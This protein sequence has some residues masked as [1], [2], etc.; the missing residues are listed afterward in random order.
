MWL[1]SLWTG[2]VDREEAH[3]GVE[4]LRQPGPMVDLGVEYVHHG[5]SVALLHQTNT[6]VRVDQ[7]G[8][9]SDENRSG[10]G[11]HGLRGGSA[12]V[13]VETLTSTKSCGSEHRLIR[14]RG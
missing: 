8:S 11:R 4:P 3:V 13:P 6:T 2:D 9:A 1:P 14:H 12:S 10:G 7:S 5:D